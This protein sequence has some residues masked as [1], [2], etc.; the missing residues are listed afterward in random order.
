M[1]SLQTGHH[2][3]ND[4]TC[5]LEELVLQPYT[6]GK[7]NNNSMEFFGLPLKEESAI[8]I[9]PKTLHRSEN[10]N[11]RGQGITLSKQRE[12]IGSI[13]RE[14]LLQIVLTLPSW[15]ILK[16]PECEQSDSL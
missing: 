10:G 12:S 8:E 11:I 6:N 14:R 15:S 4:G 13:S 7:N 2:G 5:Y 1:T 16:S 9:K 3:Y